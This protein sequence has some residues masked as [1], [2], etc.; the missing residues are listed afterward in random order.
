[1]ALLWR[2]GYFLGGGTSAQAGLSASLRPWITCRFRMKT[3]GYCAQLSGSGSA[4]SWS[5]KAD[6]DGHRGHY[7]RPTA[8]PPQATESTLT[9]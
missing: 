1:M 5:D 2:C 6:S 4:E 7:R 8:L 3:E 9:A